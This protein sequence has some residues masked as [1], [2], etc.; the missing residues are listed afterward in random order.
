M[1]FFINSDINPFIKNH[2]SLLACQANIKA[3]HHKC[4]RQNSS[5]D[6]I[7]IYPFEGNELSDIRDPIS[8]Q[9]K[10]EIQKAVAKSKTLERHYQKLILGN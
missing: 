2:P 8:K 7:E 6:C 4:L 9:A 10:A 1:G 5:V 3:S